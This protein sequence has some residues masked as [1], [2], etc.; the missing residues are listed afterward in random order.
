VGV[1]SDVTAQKQAEEKLRNVDRR[2]D[3][4][5]AML[6]HELRNPLA[7]ITMAASILSRPGVSQKTL[8]EM[9]AMVV[10]QA[11]HMTSLIDDLLDV[12]RF[13]KGLVMLGRE[14]VDLKDV[15]ASA[16]EQVRWLIEKQNHDF[17]MQVTG[18]TLRVE[19]DRIRLVQVFANILINAAKYTPEGGKILLDVGITQ[20][21]AG[22]QAKVVV[23][24]NGVGMS[25]SLLPH[26]FDIFTQGERTPDRS[27]GGLGLGL[28]L[29]KNLVGLLGGTVTARSDGA[30]RGS[31]FTVVLPLLANES[32]PVAPLTTPSPLVAGSVHNKHIMVVDDNVDAATTVA[33]LLEMEGH[34]VSVAHSAEQ[35]LA[36]ACSAALNPPQAFL[37]DIGL[38]GMDGYELAQQLRALSVT[39][40]ATLIALTGYGQ[41]QDRERSRAAGFN[42]HLEKPVDPDRLL[43][44]LNWPSEP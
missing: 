37:L 33:M 25:E 21:I 6:A 43:A 8:R 41:P 42:H 7:P 38:P 10:R 1:F 26:I 44:L 28:S 12:S 2:K 35:A 15:V 40:S 23:R 18:E 32:V 34:T 36:I 19:G 13:N 30:G 24:D 5:L 29:V 22:S 31:E 27:Q 11:G 14:A 20:S 39:A 9:S 3:E 4:F 17:S 16:V